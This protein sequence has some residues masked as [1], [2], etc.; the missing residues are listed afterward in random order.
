MKLYFLILPKHQAANTRSKGQNNFRPKALFSHHEENCLI[1][2]PDHHTPVRCLRRWHHLYQ[3]FSNQSNDTITVELL[4]KDGVDQ[5]YSFPPGTSSDIY[6]RDWQ[7]SFP[8]DGYTC[9]SDID[10]MIIDVSGG[11]TLIKDPF[12]DSNWELDAQ[13]GRNTERFCTFTVNPDDVQ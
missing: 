5:N 1:P 3:T 4:M 12:D 7:G 10:T 6:W 2:R 13:D 8:G 11:K 9:V